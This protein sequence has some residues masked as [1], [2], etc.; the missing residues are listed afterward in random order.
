MPV[1]SLWEK[2]KDVAEN[3]GTMRRIANSSTV[4]GAKRNKKGVAGSALV[5]AV[6]CVPVPGWNAFVAAILTKSGSAIRSRQLARKKGK[7]NAKAQAAGAG[8]AERSTVVKYDMKTLIKDLNVDSWDRY[9]AKVE[10]AHQQLAAAS[11]PVAI[12][13]FVEDSN[14]LCDDVL[15][16]TTAYYY[17]RKRIDLFRVELEKMREVTDRAIAWLDENERSAKQWYH[18]NCGTI[19]AVVDGAKAAEA[20]HKKCTKDHCFHRR[21]HGAPPVDPGQPYRRPDPSTVKA[22]AAAL[23]GAGLQTFDVVGGPSNPSLFGGDR[24]PMTPRE[25]WKDPGAAQ[26]FQDNP[27][28][29][30]K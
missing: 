22:L 9:R 29:R 11:S 6:K 8:A 19:G 16:L 27:F 7:A 25:A 30:K 13:A 18:D 24:K 10:Q 4:H 21:D 5:K 2:G 12:G 20:K 26:P 3:P 15:K 28:K 1:S 17:K 23:G 14:R